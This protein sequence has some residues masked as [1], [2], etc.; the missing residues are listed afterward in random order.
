MTKTDIME[1]LGKLPP[2]ERLRIIEATL[3]RVREELQGTGLP[4]QVA[5][6]RARMTAAAQALRHDYETD[7]ELTAFTTL[8]AEDVHASR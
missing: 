4:A 6:R 8:D 5:D 2:A 3:H 1:E 7:K